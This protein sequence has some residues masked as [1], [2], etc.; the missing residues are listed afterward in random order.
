MSVERQLKIIWYYSLQIWSLDGADR[1]LCDLVFRKRFAGGTNSPQK[2]IARF[3]D[4]FFNSLEIHSYN[5]AHLVRD[6]EKTKFW[7]IFT[8]LWL[9]HRMTTGKIDGFFDWLILRVKCTLQFSQTLPKWKEQNSCHW[10]CGDWAALSNCLKIGNRTDRY[11]TW[12]SAMIKSM[13]NAE[14]L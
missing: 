8:R 14:C 3:Q 7:G 11:T 2:L 5:T 13:Q 6:V 12:Y 10:A 4:H 1:S 9:T